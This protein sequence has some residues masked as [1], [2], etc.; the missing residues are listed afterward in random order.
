MREFWMRL[1]QDLGHRATGPMTF[2]LYLQ[3]LMAVLFAI[4]AGLRDARAGK[5]PFLWAL[6]TH[7]ASRASTLRDGWKSV[8]G[9]FL[10]AF[11]LDVVYQLIFQRFVYAEEAFIVAFVLAIVPYLVLRGLVTRIARR[12]MRK[13]R[14]KPC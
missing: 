4:L 10:L 5:P 8:G 13:N 2:R 12:T 3:P 6:L 14:R 7:S 11:V 1:T 9:V